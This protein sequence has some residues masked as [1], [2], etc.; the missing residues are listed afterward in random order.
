MSL[1]TLLQGSELQ[2]LQASSY[3]ASTHQGWCWKPF[4]WQETLPRVSQVHWSWDPTLS[5]LCFWT[6]WYQTPDIITRRQKEFHHT[7]LSYSDISL[8]LSCVCTQ[9]TVRDIEPSDVTKGLREEGG[10]YLPP[11]LYI[12]N[13]LC[14]FKKKHQTTPTSNK[15]S[16]VPRLLPAFQCCTKKMREPGKIVT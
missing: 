10:H 2:L 8:Y 13:R 15:P 11:P 6:K 5:R 14:E 7:T 16:L 3:P 9:L 1:P 12:V 4:H